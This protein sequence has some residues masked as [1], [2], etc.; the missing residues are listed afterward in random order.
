[1]TR[2]MSQTIRLITS[3]LMAEILNHVA[4]FMLSV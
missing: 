3:W 1:M 2:L 4:K